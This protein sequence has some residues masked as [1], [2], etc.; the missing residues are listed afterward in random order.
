MAS[1]IS[2]SS[3][4]ANIEFHEVFA[5]WQSSNSFIS[6]NVALCTWPLSLIPVQ[7]SLFV[8]GQCYNQETTEKLHNHDAFILRGG[9]TSGYYLN[10]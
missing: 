7:S 2:K 3:E 10:V 8:H 5:G 9:R 1:Q 4:A 6:R